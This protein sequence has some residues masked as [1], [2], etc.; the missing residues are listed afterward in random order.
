MDGPRLDMEG[1]VFSKKELEEIWKTL[2]DKPLPK[3]E[4]IVLETREFFR[5]LGIL[6]SGR[7]VIDLSE[8]EWGREGLNYPGEAFI[9]PCEE[10]Y[11]IC[12]NN[13][14]L[15]SLKENLIHELNHIIYDEALIKRER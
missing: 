11:Q 15:L 8:L 14:G 6:K 13:G 12:I 10:G 7:H 9:F 3:V 5:V 4:A 1:W 2:T